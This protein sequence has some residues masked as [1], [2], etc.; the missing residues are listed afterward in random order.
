MIGMILCGGLGKRLRPISED[1][2]KGLLE[3]KKGYTILDR[4]IFQFR[5]AGISR[6]LLLTAYLGEE[7]ERRFGKKHMGV[8][9]EYV[10]EKKPL[11]TLNAIRLGMEYA[12]AD[13]VVSNG[14]VV[15]DL[16]LKRMC[17]EWQRLETW[18]SIFV[19][20]MRS[21]YGI[22][23]FRGTKVMGFEEKPVLNYYING[24][25]YCL[26][27]RVLPI[28]ERYRVGDIE[29]TAFP[30]L[31]RKGKL[32]CHAE[33]GIYWVSVD[34]HKD[35]EAV[36]REYENR[37]DK[38]WGHEKL[39]KLNRQGMEKLL[40]LMAGY[41]T[42]VHYHE[43]RNEVLKVLRGR[44]WVIFEDREQAELKPGKSVRIKPGEMHS[45][46]AKTNLLLHERSSPYPQDVVRVK[47]FYDFRLG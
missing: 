20:R 16:N 46:I 41:R 25:F 10:R 30:E 32:A 17:E 26:S 7:I 18:G 1:L 23:R 12:G 22:V 21:P 35:L 4:Q 15:C 2:P 9:L 38:P 11:G 3:I 28:L 34:S 33:E 47:D 44:G 43:K 39:L 29:K 13:V 37:L 19:V 42:S 8:E 36:R 24:G 31:A 5:S 14:D 27:Q 40:Y 45:L 6:L